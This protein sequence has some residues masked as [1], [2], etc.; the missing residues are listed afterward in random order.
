MGQNDGVAVARTHHALGRDEMI[1]VSRINGN[2]VRAPIQTVMENRRIDR[3][4]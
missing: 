4:L 2:A 3:F 1:G